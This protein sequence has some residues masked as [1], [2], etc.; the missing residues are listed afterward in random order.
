MAKF[1]K[2]PGSGQAQYLDWMP[3]PKVTTM[4]KRPYPGASVCN[5][6]S[7]GV[8]MRAGS[9]REAPSP[10]GKYEWMVGALR[11]HYVT[12]DQEHMRYRK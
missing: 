5:G 7:Y 10:D 12:K 9:V 1:E 2:C 8:L 3:D 11:T 4:E 6:C